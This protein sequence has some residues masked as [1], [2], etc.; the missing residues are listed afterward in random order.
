M[1]TAR[2]LGR[3][4]QRLSRLRQIIR[5]QDIHL[6]VVDGRTL[7]LELLQHGIDCTEIYATASHW[8]ALLSE[9]A[10][11]AL[12][13][14]DGVFLLDEATAVR[15]APSQHG[16]GV[17]AVVR[18]PRHHLGPRPC[19]L[20]LDRI[21]DPGN[22]GTIIRTAAAFGVDQVL[23]SPG[24]ADPFSPRAVRASAGHSLRLPVLAGVSF[25]E[26]SRLFLPIGGGVTGT[27][28][29]G[30]VPLAHW[31]PTLPLVL[32]FGNEGSGLAPEI[33]SA[34]TS[35]V[36]IPLAEAVESLNVAV[37]AGIILSALPSPR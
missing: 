34:C 14:H 25:R 22:L 19:T 6:T 7:L 5:R 23:C 3:N 2:S 26:H 24:S 13:A 17:L 30:G 8:E 37:S 35:L 29:T 18:V 4:S 10:I 11:A 20:F 36:T 27:A 21:Q 32:A 15:I 1:P 33:L 12:Q 28:R 9:P 31:R 16:Q